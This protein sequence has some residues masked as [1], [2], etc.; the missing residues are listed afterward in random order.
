MFRGRFDHAI[1]DKGRLAVPARFRQE[2]ANLQGGEVPLIVT[3][4]KQCL[5]AYPLA[6]W[7]A[8][9]AKIEA[10]PQ[11]DPHI[12]AFQRYFLSA[13]VE[14]T[15]DKA[16]RILIPPHLRASA[17]LTQECVVVGRIKKFEIWSKSTWAAEI[18]GLETQFESIT[19]SMIQLG[20][21]L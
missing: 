17:A 8:L 21:S 18:D 16:G 15:L 14:C 9:E 11:F 19:H 7:E 1:D 20:A 12:V 5:I 6:D 3:N 2:I 10:L 13:A 4:L